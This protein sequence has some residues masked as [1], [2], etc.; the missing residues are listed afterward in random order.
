VVIRHAVQEL[1]RAGIANTAAVTWVVATVVGMAIDLTSL[2]TRATC[3]PGS[4]R[5][6]DLTPVLPYVFILL[7]FGAVG[8]LWLGRRRSP[9]VLALT[10]ATL[11]LA[12]TAV[13]ALIAVGDASAGSH[14]WTAF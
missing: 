7:A 12:L 1:R 4:A 3:R 11:A 14:C 9:R 8:T 2:A 5:L 10:G 6:I 13:T